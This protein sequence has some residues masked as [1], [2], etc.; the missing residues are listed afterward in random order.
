MPSITKK[1]I[2]S[3]TMVACIALLTPVTSKAQTV[4]ELQAQINL[5]LETLATLQSQLANLSG[6]SGIST[7]APA[8][9][10]GITFSAALKQGDSG[11]DVKCLQ[12][13]L[14]QSSDTQ[15]ESSGAGSPGN[16]TMYFGP[17]TKAA[18]IKFQNKYAPEILASWGL[19]SGTG[20]VGQTTRAKLNSL[21]TAAPGGGDGDGD[22]GGQQPPSGAG[23]NTVKLA[24]DNP[25]ASAVAKNAQNV[26]FLKVNFCAASEANT[27]SKVTV[28]RTGIAEDAD[29]SYVKLYDG[30]TQVGATQALNSTTHKAVFSSVNWTIPANSCKVLTVKATIASAATQGNSPKL[31]ISAA[32]DIVSTVALDGVFPIL[33][34][35]K[36]IAGISTGGVYVTGQTSPSGNVIAGGVE[37]PVSGLTFLASSTEAV[38]LQ[39]IT[40]TE[41]GSSVDTDV[42]NIKL[43]YG[44]T[45]LGSTVASL[46]NGK[47]TIDMSAAPLEILAGSSKKLTVYVDVGMSIGVD[48]RTIR[49]EISSNTDVSAVGVNSGGQVL[50][51][52]TNDQ[53]TDTWP[54]QGS[55]ITVV[56]G[57]LTISQ[58]T[59]YSPSAQSYSRGTLQN[60][61]IA[62]K[63]STGAN[64]AVRVTQIKLQETVSS[65]TDADVSNITLYDA[66][67]G[68]VVAGPASM[69]SGYVT[70]GSYTTGLDASGLFDIPVS[71]NKSILVKADISSAAGIGNSQLGFKITT[72]TTYIKADGLS[73]A[74]DLGADE[75]NSGS[76]TAV[77]GTDVNHNV[78]A[79]GTLTV[80]PNT[81]TA[82]AMTYAVGIQNV[83]FAT[84]DLTSTGEDILVTQFDVLF[85][86]DTSD[87]ATSTEA[88]AADIN[89]VRL[90]KG[91]VSSSNLLGTDTSISSGYANFSTNLT[92]AKNATVNVI[93]VAD[94]PLGSDADGL[95][96]WID[97][98]SDITAEGKDSGV[99]ITASAGSWTSVN[100]NVMT[101]GSPGLVIQA[102]TIP[103][104][105]T[106]VKN[107]ADVHV[108]T[109]YF[110]ASSSESLKITKIRIA[111]DAT[112]ATDTANYATTSWA[113][114]DDTTDIVVKNIVSGVKIFADGF[115]I[116]ITDISMTDGTNYDYAEFTGLSLEIPKG[117]TKSI[118]VKIKIEDSAT[119]TGIPLFFSFGIATDTT[120]I[121]GAG[122][123]SGTALTATTIIIGGGGEASQPMLFGSSGTLTVAADPNPAISAVQVAGAT[124]VTVASWKFTGDNE[125]IKI[126]TLIF[127]VNHSAAATGTSVGYAADITDLV[128]DS[129]SSK[130]ATSVDPVQEGTNCFDYSLND[131]ASSTC[132]FNWG[133]P[134]I[135]ASPTGDLLIEHLNSASST[136]WSTSSIG[137]MAQGTSSDGALQLF[138]S[139][140][141]Q[142]SLEISDC[143]GGSGTNTVDALNLG[144]KYGGLETIGRYVGANANVLNVNLYVDGVW[145]KAQPIGSTQAAKVVYIWDSGSEI[146]I[147]ITGSVVSLKLDLP[148]YI[149][150]TEGSTIK[151][152]LGTSSNADDDAYI[153]AKGANSDTTLAD[154]GING[155][156]AIGALASNEMWLYSTKPVVTKNA[157]SPTG[158]QGPASTKEV[159]RFDVENPSTANIN[160]NINAIRFTI[161]VSTTSTEPN[162]L[163][164]DRTFNLYRSDDTGTIIGTGVS[165]ANATN[166]DTT[167]WVAIYPFASAQVGAGQKST[168]ILYANTNGMA[169]DLGTVSKLLDVSIENNDFYWDDG[170]TV[171]ANQRVNNLP[172]RG[173]TL[174]Y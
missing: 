10:A 18:V 64:E 90:Y 118:D 150:L 107:S 89:N 39:S 12:A 112:S 35:Y 98:P 171:N 114:V 137:I 24:A 158:A 78:I 138:A 108:A 100:G 156:D 53:G 167:G 88:E 142:Y 33:S 75:I 1:I 111:A 77:P 126:S 26:E 115:Q 155:G 151:F 80:G 140:A 36:T 86:T 20:Y 148:S 13:L 122:L 82:A 34:N 3:V 141:G 8:V 113:E 63:F 27:V 162:T 14:N 61:I 124:G 134:L 109:L 104:T 91:S 62:F 121:A 169:T 166:T 93:V 48:S 125:P 9:C 87:S 160:V 136:C 105:Q 56:L 4:E 11:S 15:L 144:L 161:G 133:I 163:M 70:F 153:I 66:V 123:D 103:A 30:I 16:E 173:N 96:A 172:V 6:G 85:A 97:K 5:L 73:S 130:L 95:Q 21:L 17:I 67:T 52:G 72:P 45:Q 84:F 60:D 40:I 37:Q 42:S 58:D 76:T 69:I 55:S 81:N 165:T 94:V 32:S 164:W 102:S 38:K 110:T 74:N 23:Q 29:I 147:P 99:A 116:G 50:A 54:Q 139:P 28:T 146:Q 79:N 59:A 128:K 68:E 7:S 57:T 127:D 44:S 119:T 31:A 46:T 168:Y 2:A 152:T 106:F 149:A 170:L 65:T 83:N 143:E 132:Y 131:G 71:T 92:V 43:F 47:A 25:A 22:G 129:A 19:T 49:F 154:G 174:T 157:A 51:Y 41:V 120:D 159:F 117:T 101:K 145:K 135:G